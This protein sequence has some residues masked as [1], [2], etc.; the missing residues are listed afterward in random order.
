MSRTPVSSASS[1]CA[2]A[3]SDSSS[4][5][6]P[7][8]IAYRP[9]YGA[10][11]PRTSRTFRAPP[12]TVKMTTSTVTRMATSGHDQ[13][14]RFQRSTDARRRAGIES[15]IVGLDAIAEDGPAGRDGGLEDQAHTRGDDVGDDRRLRM[16]ADKRLAH[17]E[18]ESAVFPL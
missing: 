7:P 3:S 8:G 4:C 18:D 12:R 13:I 9:A 6:N 14:R 17:D 11:A 10:A 1:R 15:K 2:A 5:T 16:A